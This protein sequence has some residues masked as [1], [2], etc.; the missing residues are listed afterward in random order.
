[1]PYYNTRP[2]E[3]GPFSVAH[4]IGWWMGAGVAKVSL[5]ADHLLSRVQ[6]SSTPEKT[7]W[8][9]RFLASSALVVG[10]YFVLRLFSPWV[11]T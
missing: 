6:H 7:A 3:L 5:K 11:F 2:G 4:W 10:E 9:S 1:M 8:L